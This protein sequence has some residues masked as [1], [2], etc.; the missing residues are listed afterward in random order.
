[1][2][3]RPITQDG[4]TFACRTC[5]SCI[6]VRRQG[7]VARAM[8]EKAEWPHT[9]IVALTYDETTQE[10]RDAARFFNYGDVM[11]FLKR[12]RAAAHKQSPRATVRFL[13]AGEQ[14]SRTDRCHWH[15]V[16]YS[17]IDLR[18]LGKVERFGKVVTD[19][20]TVMTVPGGAE[21]RLHW[22]VW[23]KGFCTFQTADEGGMNYVLSYVLKDQFTVEK[24]TGTMRETKAED[25]ATGLF[26]MSKRPAIGERY[27]VKRLEAF[28]ANGDV[29]PA[30]KLKIPGF[31][32]FWVP[33]GA[34]RK[35]LL[36]H[37]RAIH[38][39]R[40]FRGEGRPPQ[41]SSLLASL[42]DD[43]PAM[44]ILRVEEN[45]EK[46]TLET[47]AADIDFR[48]RER[49]GE[50]KRRQEI[51]ARG[52]R[53]RCIWCLNGTEDSALRATGFG[54]YLTE[55]GWWR[56]YDAATGKDARLS[57]YVEV[58]FGRVAVCECCGD[59]RRLL[60]LPPEKTD[61]GRADSDD[62]GV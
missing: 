23:G 24:S 31:G 27:L 6:A 26:R 20:E 9:L 56:Y 28:D 4:N 50:E 33:S 37:L 11:R 8:M 44:E 18:Q 46:E 15:L 47:I 10:N 1:M 36:W 35:A 2:C 55:D 59:G 60:G 32:G 14:G 45:D 42:A 38:D 49:E 54:R 3:D 62:G 17:D 40:V 43:L 51:A 30:L 61:A 16:L 21:K 52:W 34:W 57:G 53:F 12:I 25:F 48:Q 41:Y 39:R 29:L 58:H 19:L 13:A 5:N 22:S 7:W